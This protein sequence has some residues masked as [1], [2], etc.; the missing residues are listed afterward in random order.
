MKIDFKKIAKI[1]GTA[2]GY[3]AMKIAT[4]WMQENTIRG[5]V[6]EELNKEESVKKEG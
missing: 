1:L 6:Q 4:D 5:I 2:A 3:A